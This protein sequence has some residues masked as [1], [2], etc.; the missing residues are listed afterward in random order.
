[1]YKTTCSSIY[2][3]FDL[4]VKPEQ[5]GDSADTFMSVFNIILYRLT[6]TAADKHIKFGAQIK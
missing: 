2:H 3:L 4:I 6:Q 5:K 1:M